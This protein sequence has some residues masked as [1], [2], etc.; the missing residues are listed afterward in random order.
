MNRYWQVCFGIT[1]AFTIATSS[2]ARAQN[3]APAGAPVTATSTVPRSVSFNGQV[4]TPKGNA[5]TGTA[6]LTFA[7]YTDQKDGTPIWTEQQSVTFDN[8]GRYSVVLGGTSADGLPAEA[9][10]AGTPRWLGVQVEGDP[11]QPRFMLLS[12]PYALKAGDAETI[13][14]KPASD[15]VLSSHLTDTV[16]STLKAEGVVTHEYPA[17]SNPTFTANALLKDNGSGGGVDSQVYDN[18]TNV[19]IGTSAPA[20]ML[21]LLSATAGEQAIRVYNFT[22]GRSVSLHLQTPGAEWRMVSNW[23][24]VGDLNFQQ[25]G[26]DR[27]MFHPNGS[28]GI[29]TVTPT[30]KLD[31]NGNTNVTGNVA[32]SGNIGAKYQ[33]VAEWVETPEPLEAGTVVIVDPTMPNRVLASPK[34]YDTRVAGAVSKQPGLILGEQSDTKTMVAQSGRVRIKADAKYGAIKIGDLLVTSPTPGYAMRSRPIRVAGQTLHRPG[35]LL[36]KALEALPNGKGEILV[37]LT[38]Q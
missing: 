16:K 4:L 22:A 24:S 2:V 20:F 37:L 26:I 8:D 5:R 9:F 13:A 18:G 34:A 25:N 33:D 6:L 19:G 35:T 10:A 11:E 14:G 29:G 38:L 23:N 12:V 27:V 30:A 21:D 17:G 31:V 28:V 36:G 15:F 1:V 3:Q 7:L 32:V